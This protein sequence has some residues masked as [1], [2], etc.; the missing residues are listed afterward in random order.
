[1]KRRLEQEQDENLPAPPW[2]WRMFDGARTSATLRSALELDV[3]AKLDAG[4]KTPEELAPMIGCP[5]RSTG[6]LLEALV[7]LDLLEPVGGP[8]YHLTQTAA[9]YLVPGK[10]KYMGGFVRILCNDTMWKAFGNLTAAIRKDGS[11]LADHAETPENHFWEIY[12]QAAVSRA[13][14]VGPPI[15]GHLHGWL[16]GKKEL[17][18]LD[19]GAGGGLYSYAVLQQIPT[20][21]ATLVEWANVVPV[22]EKYAAR[23]KIAPDR[24]RFLIGDLLELDYE[25]PYDLVLLS[26][27]LHHFDR[28]TCARVIQKVAGALAP[29]GKVAIHEF[30]GDPGSRSGALFGMTMLAWTRQGEAYPTRDYKAWIEDAGLRF[31]ERTTVAGYPVG[32]VFAEKPAD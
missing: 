15:V 9:R 7:A 8:A 21:R 19:L 12:P 24:L 32:L 26:Q 25:G 17:N 5:V 18:V 10:P 6:M 14:D 22:A 29:G 2:L 30:F 4:P 13:S 23:A 3:F 28:P 20:A 27:L 1:L 11:W 16:A 31:L